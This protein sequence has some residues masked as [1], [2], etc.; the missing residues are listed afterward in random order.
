MSFIQD[1]QN[2]KRIEIEPPDQIG[3]QR[4]RKKI[5]IV[6]EQIIEDLIARIHL[7][8]SSA[9]EIQ[10]CK[11]PPG[12]TIRFVAGRRSYEVDLTI[13]GHK[14]FLIRGDKHIESQHY[15]LPPEFEK[16]IHPYLMESLE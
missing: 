7:Q 13:T 2:V 4:G 12:F 10:R 14:H 9:E 1:I 11:V 5:V 8:V 6:S 16:S 15:Q 3:S